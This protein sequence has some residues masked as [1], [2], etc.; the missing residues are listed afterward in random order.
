MKGLSEAE[1]RVLARAGFD[2]DVIADLRGVAEQMPDIPVLRL[3]ALVRPYER[4]WLL[5]NLIAIG[6]LTI[7]FFTADSDADRALMPFAFIALTAVQF[8]FRA[9]NLAQ[10]SAPQII[11]RAI[12]V[13]ANEHHARSPSGLVDLTQAAHRLETPYVREALASSAEQ[14]RNN[15]WGAV[16]LFSAFAAVFG[17]FV[18][19]AFLS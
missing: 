10:D 18:A 15:F 3:R 5:A 11:T 12:E 19:S 6:A 1:A 16:T 4:V 2:T 9:P 8:A 14:Y 17:F 13:A 7:A